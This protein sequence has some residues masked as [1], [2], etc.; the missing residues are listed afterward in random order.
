MDKIVAV[1]YISCACN[2]TGHC[3]DWGQNGLICFGACHAVALYKPKVSQTAVTAF[4]GT[5]C[6]LSAL[7]F[8]TSLITRMHISTV[9]RKNIVSIVCYSPVMGNSLD[10]LRHPRSVAYLAEEVL[11]NKQQIWCGGAYP[12]CYPVMFIVELILEQI[13]YII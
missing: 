5:P 10:K 1:K 6:V 11:L 8:S 13:M 12:D 3:A 7:N 4:C 9:L 2:A